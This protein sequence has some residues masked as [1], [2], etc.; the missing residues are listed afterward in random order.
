MLK[1]GPGTPFFF[2]DGS[3]EVRGGRGRTDVLVE[4][5]T[6]YEPL[7]TVV[8]MPE[9]GSRDVEITLNRW[10][11]PQENNWYP[12]NTHIHYDEK[13][14]RPDD[15]LAIDCSVEGYNV[16]VVSVLDRRQLPY[17]SKQIPHRRDERP[18]RLRITSWDV[19]E[20]KPSLRRELA[21][22]F[23]VRTRNVSQ[24]PQPGPARQPRP[25]PHR[26]VRSRTIHPLCF[27]CDEARDQ[28]GIVIW[29][30]NGR[31]HGGSGCRGARENWTPSISSNPFWMDPE[32]DLWYK[33]LNCGIALPASTGTDWFVCSNNRVY[34]N[35]S[36]TFSYEKTGSPA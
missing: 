16:T 19:G 31:G 6:E 3:F 26:A 2:C 5:G 28:G 33:L 10:Y 21:L 11:F 36:D 24:H 29:C 8:D 20:E 7:R 13:E 25:H 9:H 22:G 14:T 35:T 12:G 32:Y 1:R 34:V 15:R 23:R 18:L 4:R 17:A 30:H 27:C